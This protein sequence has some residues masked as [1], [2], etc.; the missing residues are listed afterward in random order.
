LQIDL[1][2]QQLIGTGGYWQNGAGA[3][4]QLRFEL[5]V[6]RDT[7]YTSWLQI[8]DQ[9]YLWTATESVGGPLLTRLDLR[10]IQVAQEQQW[11]YSTFTAGVIWNWGG[12]PKLLHVLENH[13]HWDQALP[14]TLE[15]NK[16]AA[17]AITGTWRGE[18][19]Q[20]LAPEVAASLAQGQSLDA[21]RMA[22]QLPGQVT[23]YI[24]QGDFF[25]QRIEYRRPPA[26]PSGWKTGGESSAAEWPLCAVLEFTDVAFDEP[27]DARIFQ[28]HS[29]RQEV[30]DVTENVLLSLKLQP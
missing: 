16:T 2:D 12:L 30:L 7:Q 21:N 9:R 25:P 18:V 28:Y 1:F 26:L 22:G 8:C 13:F 17:W 15:P 29:G 3:E 4:K 14:G 23:L 5:R 10:K 24:R 27:L 6:Q 19:L 20:T 11:G